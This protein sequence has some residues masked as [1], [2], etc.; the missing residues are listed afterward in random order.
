MRSS[1][2]RPASRP[3]GPGDPSNRLQLA[4][5]AL[6]RSGTRRNRDGMAR[7]GLV[8]RKVFGVRVA[9]IHRC[10]ARLGRDHALALALW[11][12]G[13]Y[14][15]RLLA[16]FVDEPARVTAAQMDRWARDFENWGD[17][18]TTVMHLLDRTPHAWGKVG[19]WCGRKSE[20]VKRAGFA[21]IAS[22]ALHDRTAPDARFVAA[23]ALVE[24][25]ACDERIVVKKAINWALRSVGCR[26]AVLHTRTVAL[27]ARLAAACSCRGA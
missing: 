27:A 1:K 19:I 18:D 12:T 17:C 15:A 23:L 25:E 16:A 6:E 24:R 4:L 14:E 5:H 11:Q 9:E 26:T 22:L 3:T 2:E 7:Y 8:A 20:F 21:L 13:W 10:A